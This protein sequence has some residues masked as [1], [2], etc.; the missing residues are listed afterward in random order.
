MVQIYITK[1]RRLSDMPLINQDYVLISYATKDKKYTEYSKSFIKNLKD[2]NIY[3]YEIEY[4]DLPD[5]MNYWVNDFDYKRIKKEL[6]CLKKPGIIKEKLKKYNKPVICVDIDSYL[7]SKPIIP[8]QQ[9]DIAFIFRPKRKLAVTNGFHIW[10]PN[11]HTYR[12]LDM[13]SYL[14]D[15]PEFT[16]LS[17]HHRLFNLINIIKSEEQASFVDTTCKI[18]NV[19]NYYK[20]LYI[21]GINGQKE[22]LYYRTLSGKI[23]NFC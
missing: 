9:F 10:R 13:W 2:L 7:L 14:C 16:Y 6:I 1:E 18:I 15:W 5:N 19:F 20:D 3:E 12:F 23:C 11:K 21:E 8:N 17:D 4:L 22:S